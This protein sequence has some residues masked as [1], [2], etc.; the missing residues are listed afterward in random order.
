MIGNV[1]VDTMVLMFLVRTDREL[2]YVRSLALPLV[3]ILA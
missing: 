3:L 1:L 2:L